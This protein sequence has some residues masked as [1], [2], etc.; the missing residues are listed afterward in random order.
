MYEGI[1]LYFFIRNSQEPTTGF[2]DRPTCVPNDSNPLP[3]MIFSFVFL[4]YICSCFQTAFCVRIFPS[5]HCSLL[6][7]TVPCPI[8]DKETDFLYDLRNLAF[9]FQYLPS[10][11]GREFLLQSG[12]IMDVVL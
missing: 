1:S 4:F 5:K 9:S 3:T 8:S 11:N 12:D 10:H 6:V 2:D 7:C